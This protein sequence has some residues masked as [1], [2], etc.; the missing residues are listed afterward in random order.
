[1][2][3]KKPE[4]KKAAAAKKP[5]AKKAELPPPV[6]KER[7]VLRTTKLYV[8]EDAEG[9]VLGWAA[10]QAHA[11]A[12][13]KETNAKTWVEVPVPVSK[14]DLMAF[15]NANLVGRKVVI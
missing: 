6:E 2:G 14:L 13:K 3:T 15:L 8:A 9:N 11:R 4:P 12:V 7:A 10:T 5:A 1:M